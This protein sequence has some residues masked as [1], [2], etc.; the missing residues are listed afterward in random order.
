[1]DLLVESGSHKSREE[2]LAYL[3]HDH[4]GAALLRRLSKSEEPKMNPTEKLRAIAKR[5]GI[6]AIAKAIADED[7]SYLVSEH[8][9]TELVTESAKRDHPGLSD[10]QA[11]TKLYCEES[12]AGVVLRKA[13]AVVR[14]AAF[15]VDTAD[16]DAAY[17][18]LE[19]IGK[20]DYPTLPRDV[21]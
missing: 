5:Y 15:E 21:Q 12:E 4:R 16:S 7:H 18:E 20:R 13:F 14:N 11:F 3:L 2:A 19:A 8:E 1:A 17:C 9:L 10:A 6:H